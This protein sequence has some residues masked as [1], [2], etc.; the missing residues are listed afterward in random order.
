MD[1]DANVAVDPDRPEMRV[2]RSLDTMKFQPWGGGVHLEI[3]R[4]HLCRLLLLAGE[5]GQRRSNRGRYPEL[6]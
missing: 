1:D 3:E 6:G 2:T 5:P 4:R